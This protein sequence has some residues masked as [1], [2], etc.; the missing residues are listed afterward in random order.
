MLARGFDGSF[1][2]AAERPLGPRE[3]AAL[4]GFLIAVCGALAAAAALG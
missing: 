2:V 4:A 3:L 1:P